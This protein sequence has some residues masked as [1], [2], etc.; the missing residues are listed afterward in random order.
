MGQSTVLEFPYEAHPT[1]EVIWSFDDSRIK[2]DR[3]QIETISKLTTLRL[4]NAKKSDEGI[5]KAT[6]K[7]QYGEGSCSFTTKILGTM[8]FH[9]II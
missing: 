9:Y 8:L 1:P 3:I 5:F 6:L 7:N 2:T 4:K